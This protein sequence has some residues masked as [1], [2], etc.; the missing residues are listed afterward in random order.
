M[1]MTVQCTS[2]STSFPVDPAKV[3]PEGVRARCSVCGATFR[4]ER[5][6]EPTHHGDRS[7]RSEARAETAREFFGPGPTTA[8]EPE[9]ESAESEVE[10]AESEPQSAESEASA[11]PESSAEAE[12]TFQEPA[13]AGEV[14]VGGAAVDDWIIEREPDVDPGDL[15]VRRVETV[16]DG[17]RSARSASGSAAEPEAT[18]APGEASTPGAPESGA[19]GTAVTPEAPPPSPGG[20]GEVRQESQPPVQGFTFGRRDP[21]EKASRLARVLVSDIVTYNPERHQRA[22][23]Q[24]TLK[25]DFEDE[26]KK[27][28]DEYVDQVGQDLADTTAYFNDALNEILARGRELF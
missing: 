18:P 1:A 13:G 14:A 3:P 17:L 28:W 5:P 2:C 11:E 19:A 8:A 6:A 23:E 25:E 26:I 12:P 7:D 16:E 10:S 22:L 20:P 21:H 24:G 27:S 15:D 9:P 4:V